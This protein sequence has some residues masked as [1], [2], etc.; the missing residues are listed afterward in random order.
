[1]STDKGGDIVGVVGLVLSAGSL[2]ASCVQVWLAKVPQ[3]TII[4]T[5]LDGA[6]RRLHGPREAREDDEC[7]EQFLAGGS[8]PAGGKAAEGAS[9][10]DDSS[11][12][13]CRNVRNNDRYAL[14]IGASGYDSDD[15][16]DLPAV[17]ADLHYMQAV[18]QSPEIGLY[19]DC[20]MVPDPTRAEMLHGIESFLE[21]RQQSESA[22]LYF[23]G[24]GEFCEADNQLYFLTRDSDRADLPRTAVSAEFLER[25]LQSSRAA[26]KIVLLDCCASGSVVQGW[27]SKGGN[28]SDSGEEERTTRLRPTGVY[29]ITASDALQAASAM[30]PEGST[31]G[32]SRFTGGIV[33]GLRNGR[34]KDSGWISPDDLFAYLTTQMVRKGVPE[35]QRPTRSTILATHT[36][37]FARSV[38]RPVA[39][40]TPPD[41]PASPSAALLKARERAAADSEN[42]GDWQRLLRYYA[43]CLSAQAAA[44]MLP[45]PWLSRASRPP[46][47][48]T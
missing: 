23:S 5:R 45:A 35:E 1:M 22:L 12:V 2:A 34:V 16:H 15:Y 21:E 36:L 13:G 27:R 30:A 26:S 31:L 3:R 39:L 29:F 25:T 14:L 33:E 41:E 10:Q 48:C 37:Y 32:T 11:T 44:S 28:G 46:S 9:G 42:A 38:A 20:E 6:T 19:N 40:P 7:L 24:H 43:Q 4:A 47:S 8:L 17:R 18:L